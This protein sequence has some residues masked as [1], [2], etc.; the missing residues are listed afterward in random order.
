MK[1]FIASAVLLSFLVGS[2]AGCA[3]KAQSGAGLGA[4]TGATVGALTS[5][6]KVSG[7]AIGAGIGLLLGYMVGNEMDK[8]D[9]EQINNALE[10]QPSG[11]SFHAFHRRTITGEQKT[12]IPGKK[13]QCANHGCLILF[14]RERGRHDE[15]SVSGVTPGNELLPR[16]GQGNP[17]AL[18]VDSVV[19]DHSP[20][21]K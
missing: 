20:S 17:D 4:L 10:T 18:N 3:N 19:D 13:P 15:Q 5:K 12:K 16:N 11:K 8:H 1:R 6:N 21:G 2:L 14:P 7:A 9:K